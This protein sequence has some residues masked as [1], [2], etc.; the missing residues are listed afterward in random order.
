MLEEFATIAVHA[1]QRAV[2]LRDLATRFSVSVRSCT[3]TVSAHS[4]TGKTVSVHSS[5]Q[6]LGAVCALALGAA[7]THA[8]AVAHEPSG[9]SAMCLTTDFMP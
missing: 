4:C 5:T 3:K 8:A 9:A 6:A 7:C 1:V 2:Q